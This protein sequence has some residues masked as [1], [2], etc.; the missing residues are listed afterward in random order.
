MVCSDNVYSDFN[1]H[2]PNVATTPAMLHKTC[3]FFPSMHV[4]YQCACS[5]SGH[6]IYSIYTARWINCTKQLHDAML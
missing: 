6:A 5:Y 1:Q 2:K 3:H 4:A